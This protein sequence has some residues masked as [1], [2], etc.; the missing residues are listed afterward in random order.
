[1]LGQTKEDFV[2]RFPSEESCIRFLEEVRWAGGHVRSPFTGG[3]AYA[4]RSRPGL[5]KC[6]D[7]RQQFTVRRG[8][9][10]EESHLPL[11]KWFFCIFL[12]TNVKERASSARI[13]DLLGI[14]QKTAWYMLDRIKDAASHPAF[15]AS[16]R[17]TPHVA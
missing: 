1:V 2:K 6:K 5:Y 16:I 14:T 9:I 4:I 15:S 8:T 3:E 13:A 7:T 17:E 10:F 12:L 11:R